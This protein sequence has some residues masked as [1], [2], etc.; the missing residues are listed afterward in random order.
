MCVLYCLLCGGGIKDI[1]CEVVSI[2]RCECQ[3]LCCVFSLITVINHCCLWSM[4]LTVCTVLN[5]EILELVD[6]RYFIGEWLVHVE[7]MVVCGVFGPGQL[8]GCGSPAAQAQTLYT[9]PYLPQ[10][11]AI[12]RQNNV[13]LPVS[14]FPRS[15]QHIQL[16]P[17]SRDNS[18]L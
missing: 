10:E 2:D 16:T 1:C 11:L 12:L 14:I 4:A 6:V 17:Y 9:Q 5:E 3:V 18:D 15:T 13:H 8:L 7:G